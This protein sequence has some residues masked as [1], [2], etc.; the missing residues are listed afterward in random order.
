[1]APRLYGVSARLSE[2]VG[3]Q[4]GQKGPKGAKNVK[5]AGTVGSPCP[6]AGHLEEPYMSS[7]L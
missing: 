6:P 4:R 3:G 7:A 1:M 2:D 5:E